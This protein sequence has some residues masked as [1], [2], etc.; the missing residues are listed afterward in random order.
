M[1]VVSTGVVNNFF[2]SWEIERF[3]EDGAI[4][5]EFQMLESKLKQG[6]DLL[7]WSSHES[8]EVSIL[9]ES[10]IDVMS[11]L[12]IQANSFE[13]LESMLNTGYILTSNFPTKLENEECAPVINL[14]Y[15][16]TSEWSGI[17]FGEQMI[18]Q[19]LKSDKFIPVSASAICMSQW[20]HAI[21]NYQFSVK[22]EFNFLRLLYALQR[23]V[24][25][26]YR[27][28][29]IIEENGLFMQNLNCK[30]RD[31]LF[32]CSKIHLSKNSIVY[33]INWRSLKQKNIVSK[34]K[35]DY[36][37]KVKSELTAY[38]LS[39]NT[40]PHAIQSLKFSSFEKL[41]PE[42]MNFL[43]ICLVLLEP[44]V[45]IAKHRSSM[46]SDLAEFRVK[47]AGH[48]SDLY[49]FK[50]S[51]LESALIALDRLWVFRN[52]LLDPSEI[53]AHSLK[54]THQEYCVIL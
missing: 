36:L 38:L 21:P 2:S 49:S 53:N 37:T 31:L 16:S 1:S 28:E 23:D 52:E 34:I 32:G 25:L 26:A 30:R 27:D 22:N 51:K 45:A 39:L 54:T 48:T 12:A 4:A 14:H 15:N 29:F 46:E 47:S 7:N 33:K 8:E 44:V 43:P 6:A 9:S 41:T 50:V 42:E 19:L 40:N 17:Q 18:P 3:R 20:V 35:S 10:S 11:E 5:P 24:L 13:N